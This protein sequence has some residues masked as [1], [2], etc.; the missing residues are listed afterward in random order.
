[1]TRSRRWSPKSSRKGAVSMCSSPMP[2]AAAAAA[3]IGDEH[4][5][6]APLRDDFGDHRLDRVMIRDVELDAERFAAVGLYFRDRCLARHV[7]RF[8]LEFLIGAQAQI[9]DRDL[10]A[11][12]GEAARIGS[13][14]PARSA[15]DDR[16]LVVE[17]AHRTPSAK[18]PPPPPPPPTGGGGPGGGGGGGGVVGARR[19]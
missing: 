6:T 7:A 15:G 14:Q 16:N 18:C 4:I 17:L 3:G 8:G 1:M 10:A 12:A 9:G 5:D 11:E 13:S 2:A 19:A